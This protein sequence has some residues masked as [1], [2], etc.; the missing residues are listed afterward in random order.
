MFHLR[1]LIT[2][3][4]GLHQNMLRSM[5]A[6]LG[7]VIGVGAVIAAVSILEGAQKDILE[8][9]E[10]LGADQV[11]VMNGSDRRSARSVQ[12]SSLEPEDADHVLHDGNGLIIET[13]PQVTNVAQV[14]YYEKNVVASVLGTA[15]SYARVNTYEVVEGEFITREDV[16]GATMNCVL[17]H[18]VAEDLFGPRPCLGKKVKINGK[19]FNVIGRMEERG[20]IGFV[21]VDKQVVI[22]YTTAMGRMFG[23]RHLSMLVAQCVDAAKLPACID[24]V[25]KSLRSAHRIRAGEPD[26]FQVFSQERLKQDFGQVAQIFAIVLYSIAGI[27]LLVGA[28]GIMNIMLVS[29]TE[30]TREIGVRIAVGARRLDILEQFLAEASIISSLGGAFGVLCGWA[31]ANFISEFTQVLPTHTPPMIVALA[32]VMAFMVGVL[33]G[34]YPA[35]RASRLD[36]V[37]A[38]RFE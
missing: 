3:I 12:V 19:T 17:G 24:N 11:L 28:I 6:T 34:I 10:A 32:L 25:R 15:A 16:R 33:S 1:I 4:R 26:D 37:T 30:R 5:L 23:Q 8:R 36:P 7:V 22:P 9:F 29:V 2:A 13:V 18:K 20:T 38:L 31:I 14:K 21:E 27:S 35:V